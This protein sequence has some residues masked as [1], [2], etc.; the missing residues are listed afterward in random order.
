MSWPLRLRE[1]PDSGSV[2]FDPGDC[3][4]ARPESI[5][6]RADGSRWIWG[7]QLSDEYESLR[8]STRLPLLVKLPYGGD[9]C[10]DSAV[11]GESRGW[12]VTGDPPNITVSPSINCVNLYH[13]W[14]RDG[15]LTDDVD[16]RRYEKGEY[17]WRQVK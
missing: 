12:T 6:T 1:L 9:F 8:A 4:Y 15:E 17:G 7:H 10:V 2:H 14:I 3:F 16:G 13:G 5:K 11:T